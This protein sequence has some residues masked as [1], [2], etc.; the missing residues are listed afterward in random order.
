MR[1]LQPRVWREKEDTEPRFSKDRGR[2]AA[3]AMDLLSTLPVLTMAAL[4]IWDVTVISFHQLMR[5][6]VHRATGRGSGC[7][8]SEQSAQIPWL[9]GSQSAERLEHQKHECDWSACRSQRLC[10]PLVPLLSMTATTGPGPVHLRCAEWM[11]CETIPR[12][13]IIRGTDVRVCQDLL[14]ELWGPSPVSPL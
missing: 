14:A 13:T 1:R 11:E 7:S 8:R 3:V 4:C 5:D 6:G 2:A 10:S 12:Y 9:R